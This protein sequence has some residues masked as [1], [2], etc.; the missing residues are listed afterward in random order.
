MNDNI[1]KLID[2]NATIWVDYLGSRGE[3]GS[4]SWDCVDV[5]KEDDERISNVYLRF[6]G[7]NGNGV[8]VGIGDHQLYTVEDGQIGHYIGHLAKEDAETLL[9]IYCKGYLDKYT[10]AYKNE[11]WVEEMKN[12]GVIGVRDHFSNICTDLKVLPS[13]LYAKY[14]GV[15][16]KVGGVRKPYVLNK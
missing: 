6:I 9:P 8:A 7:F 5:V 4:C 12:E 2:D 14:D 1:K 11:E 10:N 15:S 3:Y 16:Q 13:D